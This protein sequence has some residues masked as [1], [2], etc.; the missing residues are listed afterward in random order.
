MLRDSLARPVNCLVVMLKARIWL[1]FGF[2]HKELA[3]VDILNLAIYLLQRSIAARRFGTLDL[4]VKEEPK[5]P[6]SRQDSMELY[7]LQSNP[8]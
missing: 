8:K 4:P 2:P 7:L 5:P 3:F 6:N 1:L